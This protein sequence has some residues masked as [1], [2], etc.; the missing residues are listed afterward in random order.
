MSFS[1]SIVFWLSLYNPKSYSEE[2]KTVELEDA[3][4]EIFLVLLQRKYS[5]IL[6]SSKATLN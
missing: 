1:N 3:F 2:Q 5:I 6:L 4:K